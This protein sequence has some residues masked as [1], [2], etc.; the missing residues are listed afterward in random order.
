LKKIIQLLCTLTLILFITPTI[1]SQILS[2]ELKTEKISRFEKAEWEIQLKEDFVNPYL[3]SEITL[4]MKMRSPSGKAILLPC[5]YVSGKSGELS[6]WKA[7]F[8]PQEIGAYTYYFELKNKDRII[9]SDSNY[10]SVTSSNKKGFLHAND[11]WTFKFDNGELFRGIGENIGWEARKNDD[12]K[13]FKELHEMSRFNYEY[14]LKKLKEN[15]GNYMRTWM[16]PWNLPLEWKKVANT[17]R[18]I[19]S[20]EYFNPSSFDKIERLFYLADS[21]GIYVMLAMDAHGALLGSQWESSNYNI[22]NGGFAANPSEF[23]SNE[24]SKIQYKSRL[25]YL[26]ARWGHYSSIGAW[27]F[28]NEVDNAM[29][30]GKEE[31]Q[32]DPEL[33]VQWHKEMSDYLSSIDP[34]DHL[35]TTSISHREIEG[36]NSIEKIDFNQ[37]HIYIATDAIPSALIDYSK[38]F[39]K[40]YVIGEY[41]HQWDWSLNFNEYAENFDYD[42]KKGLWYGL[43]NPTPILPM[44]W[45]WEFFDERNTKVYYS[46]VKEIYN[47]MLDS[48]GGRFSSINVSTDFESG[49]CYGVQC[50]YKKF[51]YLLNNGSS[52]VIAELIIDNNEDIETVQVYDPDIMT[53]SEIS[54]YNSKKENTFI[55]NVEL[56][57]RENKIFIITNK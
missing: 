2:E 22:K 3:I 11:Y 21:L 25:R 1:K 56:K 52:D 28:W 5:F 39:S 32:I 12:S 51:I 50:G 23:F 33:V 42:F 47:N 41:G 43:F 53:Y 34:Y 35:I 46:N 57:R 15:G 10:F 7:I 38:K 27:E 19:N 55:N 20:D 13:F 54:N 37:K 9:K 30:A 29:Y 17:N 40:P 44:T 18:Y 14:M 48:G 26:V 45:W 36:L 24:K 16:C 8:S 4:D 6:N 31:S 49:I